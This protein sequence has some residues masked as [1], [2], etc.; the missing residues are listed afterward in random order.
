MGRLRYLN[1]FKI[2][3]AVRDI[4]RA[5]SGGGPKVLRLTHVGEPRGIFPVA[6]VEFEVEAMDG[7]VNSFATGVPVPWPVG[8]A[9]RIAR[10][11]GIPVISDIDHDEITARVPVPRLGR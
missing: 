8:W 3:S 6:E 9:Y 5:S 11:L 2:R 4:R 7:S 10:K 1:P